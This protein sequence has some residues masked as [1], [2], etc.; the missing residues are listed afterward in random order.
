MISILHQMTEYHYQEYINAFPT[1]TDLLDFL[2]EIFMVF[3]DLISKN[4]YPNDWA[5]MIVQQNSV[6]LFAMKQYARVL[7]RSSVRIDDFEFQLW[8]NFFHLA[9]AFVTQ[10]SLQLENFSPAKRNKILERFA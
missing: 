3:R 9:V 8:N 5:T 10:E 1:R 6:I 7:Q 2:M 4:L